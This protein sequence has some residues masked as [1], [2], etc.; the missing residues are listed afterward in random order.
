VNISIVNIKQ[1]KLQLSSN[2]VV[3]KFC[4]SIGKF[5]IVPG[6]AAPGM[7]SIACISVE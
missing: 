7:V 6:I 3:V 5:G 1:N 4:N 2:Q